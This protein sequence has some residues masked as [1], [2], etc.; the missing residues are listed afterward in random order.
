MLADFEL[1]HPRLQSFRA[2]RGPSQDRCETLTRTRVRVK[3]DPPATV[4]DVDPDELVAHAAEQGW[5]LAQ[6]ELA[7]QT[8]WWWRDLERPDDERQPCWTERRQTI[9]YMADFLPRSRIH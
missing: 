7:G 1:R 3:E 9:N 5:Q 8:V 2:A 6:R 4:P